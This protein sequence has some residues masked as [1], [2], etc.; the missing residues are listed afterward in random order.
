MN[1][2]TKS[3]LLKIIQSN[4]YFGELTKEEVDKTVQK[5]LDDIKK[6]KDFIVK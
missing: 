5:G 3:K 1:E 2:E 4:I 6:D